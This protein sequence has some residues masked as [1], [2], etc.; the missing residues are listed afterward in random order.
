MC[1]NGTN[2][3]SFA[4]EMEFQIKLIKGKLEEGLLGGGGLDKDPSPGGLLI[5]ARLL[6]L[7]QE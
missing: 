6:P 3:V 1:N 5:W 4:G 2:F 7:T